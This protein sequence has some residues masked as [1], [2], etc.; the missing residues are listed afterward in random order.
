MQTCQ[1]NYC[2]ERRKIEDTVS[3]VAKIGM[4]MK[5]YPSENSFISSSRD[6]KNSP[7]QIH[8]NVCGDVSFASSFLA[9]IN[10]RQDLCPCLN[11]N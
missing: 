7:K 4:P 9:E 10:T 11:Y 6:G 1:H 8:T 3:C 2:G 5:N